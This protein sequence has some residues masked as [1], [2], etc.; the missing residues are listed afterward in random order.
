MSCSGSPLA[1]ERKPWSPQAAATP[2]HRPQNSGVSDWNATPRTYPSTAPSRMTRADC[3]EKWKFW[4]FSS[5]EYDA[6][7]SRR[8]PESTPRSRSAYATIPGSRLT[9]TIRTI[10]KCCQPS[11]RAEHA[12]VIPTERPHPARQGRVSGHRHVGGSIAKLSARLRPHEGGPGECDLMFEEPIGLGG[13]AA[14]LMHQQREEL[15]SEYERRRTLGREWRVQRRLGIVA[16]ARRSRDQ[17]EML[18]VLPSRLSH[19]TRVVAARRPPT[20]LH[21]PNF[22]PPA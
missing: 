22:K 9:F 14:R 19:Q 7:A 12:V 21:R 1:Q 5:S 16:V 8:S 4:R 17:I 11:A 6:G 20:R 13:M 15:R 2:S 3:V 18:D 10:G